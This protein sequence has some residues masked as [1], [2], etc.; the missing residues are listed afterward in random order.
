MDAS[1]AKQPADVK[2]RMIFFDVFNGLEKGGILV[3]TA[4]F[5]GLADPRIILQDTLARTNILMTYFRVA[6]LPLRQADRLS[7]GL[8]RSM[9]PFV[10]NF[11]DIGGASKGNS[12]AFFAW[13]HTP[14][15]H[16]YQDKRARPPGCCTHH[17]FFTP[18][19]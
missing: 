16:N 7:R 1:I 2:L 14:A 3:K 4:I 5:N 19:H 11:I 10:G 8:D 15:V 12:V 18:L 13:V 6:H 17:Y 9:G